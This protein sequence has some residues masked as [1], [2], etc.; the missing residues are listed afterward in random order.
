MVPVVP[1][2]DLADVALAGSAAHD[3]VDARGSGFPTRARPERSTRIVTGLRRKTRQVQAIVAVE[4]REL[5]VA[6]AQQVQGGVRGHPQVLRD[7]AV[8]LKHWLV[9]GDAHHRR[10]LDPVGRPV[11]GARPTW[12]ACCSPHCPWSRRAE[13]GRDRGRCRVRRT[14]IGRPG[15][16]NARVRHDRLPRICS[17]TLGA[18]GAAERHRQHPLPDVSHDALPPPRLHDAFARVGP[19]PRHTVDAVKCPFRTD[20]ASGRRKQLPPET[21]GFPRRSRFGPRRSARSRTAF[22]RPARFPGRAR[23]GAAPPGDPWNNPLQ[24]AG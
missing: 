7:A 9:G 17:P 13:H 22:E 15:I 20:R 2:E 21:T 11:G 12:R 18:R 19:M 3:L 10:L 1:D 4:S 6:G 23:R 14:R 8:R 16:R 5:L 24:R